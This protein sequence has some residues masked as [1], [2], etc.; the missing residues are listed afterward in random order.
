MMILGR[1]RTVGGSWNKSLH[2]RPLQLC[3]SEK[4]GSPASECV[5]RR[6]YS[7]TYTQSLLAVSALVPVGRVGNLVCERPLYLRKLIS[8]Y[9]LHASL[10]NMQ[11]PH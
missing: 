3:Y 6:H 11:N 1:F 8:Y 5:M 4:S 9:S 2:L 7:I 10:L